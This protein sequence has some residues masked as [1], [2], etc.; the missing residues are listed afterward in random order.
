MTPLS[1]TTILVPSLVGGVTVNEH[2]RGMMW[3][4]VPSFVLALAG[5]LIVGLTA[6]PS[7]SA[8][9]VDAARADA[10]RRLQHL[11][12]QPAAA[13]AADRGGLR[14]GPAVPGHLR[15]RP[16]L[17]RPGVVH[18]AGRRAG[19]RRRARPGRRA[20]RDR[21]DLRVDGQ[22]VRL[23][24][25]QRHHRRPV[26]A[27]RHG[28][29]ADHG[30]AHPRRAELRRHHGGGRLPRPAD[31]ARGAPGPLRTPASSPRSP[32][33]A[34]GSTWWRATSTWPT[35]CRAGSTAARSPARAWPPGCCRARS[36]T[37]GR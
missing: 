21:G 24:E 9:G 28:Q 31:R 36:R 6:D 15:R 26:L 12:A 19:L 20:R 30:L 17:R 33:P 8:V 29:H 16:V 10:G 2:I 35:S 22:R 1:E 7:S 34:S 23:D 27:G 3:T 25:R 13:G 14:A 32:A 18:P 5:F 4:V 11:A 37:R